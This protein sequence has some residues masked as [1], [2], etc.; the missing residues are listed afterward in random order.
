MVVCVEL[1]SASSGQAQGVEVPR[2]R[3][4]QG[5]DTETFENTCP[6]ELRLLQ[7]CHDQDTFKITSRDEDI[8][9][10]T[11]SLFTELC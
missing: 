11:T 7:N 8:Y 6:D 1:E 2:L 9:L 10:E 5:Q 4:A 3:M